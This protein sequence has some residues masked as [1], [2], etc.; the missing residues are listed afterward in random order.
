[1]SAGST[2]AEQLTFTNEIV[3]LNRTGLFSLDEGIAFNPNVLQVVSYSTGSGLTGNN[4]TG[5]NTVANYNATRTIRVG[6]YTSNPAVK[7]AGAVVDVLDIAF[8]VKVNATSSTL[9]NRAAIVIT[10]GSMTTDANQEGGPLTLNPA[11]TNGFD[12]GVDCREV[13]AP[14]WSA[15]LRQL[16]ADLECG[17]QVYF[18]DRDALER[19]ESSCFSIAPA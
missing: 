3:P 17:E 19:L 1:M 13:L 18:E 10:N 16:E 11:P 8:Q 5:W 15:F 6:Q 9:V 14:S 7:A 4:G 2:F 12:P